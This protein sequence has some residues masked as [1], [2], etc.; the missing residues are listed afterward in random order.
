MLLGIACVYNHFVIAPKQKALDAAHQFRRARN[1]NAEL[2]NLLSSHAERL[3]DRLFD[4]NTYDT[5]IGTLQVL[6]NNVYTADT[7]NQL[8]GRQKVKRRHVNALQAS[9]T[10][11][12]QKQQHIKANLNGMV[13]RYKQPKTAA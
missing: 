8:V 10:H 11:Q 1:L 12:L 6:H 3:Q 2:I 4:G 13:L 7:F 5:T 9:I